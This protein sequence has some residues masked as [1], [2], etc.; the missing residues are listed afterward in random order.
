VEKSWRSLALCGPLRAVTRDALER[1]VT[2]LG[3][4]LFASPVRGW[5]RASHDCG[6]PRA[7][8]DYFS[9]PRMASGES[10]YVSRPRMASGES[11]LRLP[12]SWPRA[13]WNCVFHR[14]CPRANRNCISHRGWPRASSDCIGRLASGELW[15]V[16]LGEL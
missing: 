1:L 10:D 8:R 6:R 15:A 2:T 3:R 4:V 14:G 16:A 5:S 13:N 9:R 11:K 12:T 7:S